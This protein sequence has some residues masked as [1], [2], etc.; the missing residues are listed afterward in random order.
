[1]NQ[2]SNP[3]LK[4]NGMKVNEQS[5]RATR[6]PQIRQQHR[7]MNWCKILDR[8][9]F[10]DDPVINQK[11]DA[12]TT[13]EFHISVDQRKRFLTLKRDSTMLEIVRQTFF[14]CRLQQAR[15]QDAMD[16]NRSANYFVS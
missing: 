14:V 16:L 12:I 6:E 9:K 11:I 8:L 7:V 15:S 10:D 2:P 4:H 13:I 1:M 5:N 3:I